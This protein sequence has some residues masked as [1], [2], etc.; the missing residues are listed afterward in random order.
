MDD[1]EE[2]LDDTAEYSNIGDVMDL[3]LD[4]QVNVNNKILVVAE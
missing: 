1:G 2:L 4:S 3:S